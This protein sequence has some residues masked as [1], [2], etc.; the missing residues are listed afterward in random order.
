MLK[1][2]KLTLSLI[3]F[4]AL[5]SVLS[6]AAVAQNKTVVWERHDVELTVNTDG[7]MHVKETQEITFLTGTFTEGF[8]YRH[9]ANTE[10]LRDFI[11]YEPD[12]PYR[13]GRGD[14]YTYHVIDRGNQYEIV[15]NFP[16]EQNATRT[17][18]MEYIVDGPVRQYETGDVLSWFA[19]PDDHSFPIEDSTITIN[20]PEGTEFIREPEIESANRAF[21]ETSLD[22]RTATIEVAG[23]IQP[24]EGVNVRVGFAH[25]AIT[26]GPP[27][28]QAAVDAQ[29]AADAERARLQPLFDLG[30]AVLALLGLIFGPLGVYM[31]WFLRGKDPEVSGVPDYITEPPSDLA[32]GIVGVLIDEQ[33]DMHD[34]TATLV[35][36][37]RRGFVELLEE[38]KAG[39][40]KTVKKTFV[41]NKLAE[42]TKENSSSYERALFDSFFLGKSKRSVTATLP[43][44]FHDGLPG[45]KNRMYQDATTAGLFKGAPDKVRAG[46]LTLGIISLIG[47]VLFLMLMMGIV[48]NFT[49]FAACIGIGPI[50]FGLSLC[51]M[52]R[53]MPVKTEAGALEAAK[54][55]AFKTYMQNIDKYVD[56][57]HVTDQ[58]EKYLPYAI[59]FGLERRWIHVFSQVPATPTPGWYRPVWV[60]GGRPYGR[61]IY[62]PGRGGGLPSAG[63]DRKEGGGVPSLD[64]IGMGMAG[65][66]NS[67][68]DGLVGALNTMGRT[69]STPPAPPPGSGSSSTYRGGGSS[70]WGGGGGFSGGGGGFSGGGGG[71][72]F[73]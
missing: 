10:D 51:V 70:G 30:A 20:L 28:W 22:N 15:W 67:L 19:L 23:P 31:L 14:P 38:Q 66:L 71:G 26:V 50:L 42:P 3:V 29:I 11:V 17:Y 57:E 40:F 65:G 61:G 49:S 33:A 45:I 5:F 25:G 24:G 69:I 27:S 62:M 4:L 13:E 12:Q 63:G 8:V 73:R 53:Y 56:L 21:W 72:G 2:R 7:T 47:G 34:I 16:Q 32:P 36:F 54:W 35:D 41:F 6:G 39:A 52:S 1:T 60:G 55:N 58:F 48:S 37:A 9:K 68:G 46:Y 18:I 43:R 44:K 59:A 64:E